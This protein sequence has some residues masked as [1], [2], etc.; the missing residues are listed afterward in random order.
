M[1][2]PTSIPD[3]GIP[4]GTLSPDGETVE[5]NHQ[6]YLILY[7]LALQALGNGVT[8]IPEVRYDFLNNLDAETIAIDALNIAQN[9]LSGSPTV[10]TPIGPSPQTLI[11]PS[12]G[13]YILSGGTLS[14]ISLT[15]NGVSVGFQNTTQII[16][17]NRGDSVMLT[18]T[19]VP[20]VTF[21][22]G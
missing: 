3:I 6:W 14:F 13:S 2:L 7:N 17:V 20:S 18:F 19:V 22:P 16:P 12:I 11:A 4:I 10:S 1:P 15:R 21:L 5:M 8:T 9:G